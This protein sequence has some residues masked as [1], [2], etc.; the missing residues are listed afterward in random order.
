MALGGAWRGREDSRPQQG[1]LGA[2]DPGLRDVTPPPSGHPRPSPGQLKATSGPSPT[3]P[4]P[5]YSH[6]RATPGPLQATPG[7]LPGHLRP[8]LPRRAPRPGTHG[9][10]RG[11][12]AE[13]RPGRGCSPRLPASGR[14]RGSGQRRPTAR[15]SHCSGAAEGGGRASP[16]A[17]APQTPALPARP[18]P[19]PRASPRHP[20]P[21]PRLLFCPSD[22]FKEQVCGLLK[23]E[24]RVAK[25][26]RAAAGG[27]GAGRGERPASVQRARPSAGTTGYQGRSR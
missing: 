4:E 1:R 24:N 22:S 9:A 19:P 13:A 16:R 23:S 25:N 26:N 2:R 17:G 5:P 27:R 8:T 12:S 18:S 15:L 14:L 11:R 7:P 3:N 10:R 20:T 21:P 6:L